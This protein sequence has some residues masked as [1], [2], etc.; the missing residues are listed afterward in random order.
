MR[1]LLVSEHLPEAEGTASGRLLRA[2]GQGLV[3]A[4]HEVTAVC[5]TDREPAEELPPWAS[6]RPV[7]R[8]HAVRDHLQALVRP[9]WASA[10]LQL[11][12]DHDISFAEDPLSWA[13]VAGHRRT[14]VVVHY[15]CLVD[16]RALGRVRPHDLQGHRADRRAVRGAAV[17]LAYSPRVAAALGGRTSWLPAAVDVPAEPLP[18]RPE[19]RALL[20]AG[21]DWPPNQA[22]LRDLLAAWP[23]VRQ[24]V[25][26]A[27]LLL[28][29]RGCPSVHAD[30]V[31]VLGEVPRAV[32][33]FAEAAVLAF[34]C[35]PTSGPKTKVLEALA[36]GLPVVTTEAGAEGLVRPDGCWTTTRASFADVLA[37]ALADGQ[38]RA[39]AAEA[40]RALVA[41]HHSPA[42]AAAARLAALATLVP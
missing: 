17:P 8:G 38:A 20:L 27:E 36:A 6:W 14:G 30:G 21:W 33:A 15:S 16:A 1:A 9:R 40:G 29:G 37:T 19:P 41:A 34:P 28:A 26:G 7:A 10:A 13:A 25:P 3:D 39:A 32:D 2:A 35:P 4:G 11:P 31:R 42:A 5:W 24:R 12:D 23:S 18:L 22:A